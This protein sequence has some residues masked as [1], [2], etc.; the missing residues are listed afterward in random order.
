MHVLILHACVHPTCMCSSYMHVLILHACAHPTCVHPT[1]MCSSCMR[2][3][4]LT[5]TAPSRS[6]ELP[7]SSG[8]WC[9]SDSMSF[10]LRCEAFRVTRRPH[11]GSEAAQHSQEDVSRCT[12][13]PPAAASSLYRLW[14]CWINSAVSKFHPMKHS[15]DRA[16]LQ[17]PWAEPIL[18]HVA[19]T[20]K[21][22]NKRQILTGEQVF[23]FVKIE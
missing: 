13:Q 14:M 5:E 9:L 21:P 8:C 11:G 17:V 22:Q 15:G 7:L 10:K 4:A 12:V 20:S 2:C 3:R 1:C 23:C 19:K 18:L 16:A 6:T